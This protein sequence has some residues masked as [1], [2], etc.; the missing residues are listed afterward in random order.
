MLGAKAKSAVDAPP[1]GVG[2]V[3]RTAL[4]DTFDGIRFEI[5]RMIKY[6]QAAVKDPMVR[7]QFE[8]ICRDA[9]SPE[10]CLE[11]IDAWCR[12]HY[13]YLNDPPGI[14]YVQTPRRM[15][16]QTRVP[17]E[18]IRKVME[19][20]YA[21]LAE[22]FGPA[23]HEYEPEGLCFG[24][25]DEGVVLYDGL[26]AVA[27]GKQG[28]P[29]LRPVLMRFGGNDGTLHHVWGKAG[30]GNGDS[31]DSDITEPEYQL[32]EYSRFQHY[33]EVEVPV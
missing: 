16:K 11:L 5:A 4:P 32:G 21:A 7:A 26:C 14:E 3:R 18:V 12:Q 8:A 29:L 30:N 25:C 23:A 33:E 22:Q 10:E 15:I 24:D 9:A 2:E 6:V 13:I 28:M 31:R 27:D 20:Y 17:S 19:P 1:P